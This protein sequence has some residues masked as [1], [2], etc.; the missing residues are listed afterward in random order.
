MPVQVWSTTQF[1][2]LLIYGGS[3]VA[4]SKRPGLKVSGK[5]EDGKLIV[6]GVF[7]LLSSTTGLPLEIIIS[8]FDE[9]NIIIDWLDLYKSSIEGGWSEKTILNK[10]ETAIGDCYGGDYKKEFMKRLFFCLHK[11]K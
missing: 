3:N 4:K 2:I 6:S 7:P 9:N 11:I 1:F 5:T 10:I 8:F